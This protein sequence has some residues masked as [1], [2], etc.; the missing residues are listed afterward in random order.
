M[1]AKTS[2]EIMTNY[3]LTL[4]IAVGL[5]FPAFSQAWKIAD[6]PLKTPW[7]EQVNPASVLPEYPRPQMTRDR[8]Q[9]LNG[10]WEFQPAVCLGVGPVGDSAATA[11]PTGLVSADLY[12]AG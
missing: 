10:V 6:A 8:W 11:H 3:V 2:P 4:L 1:A 5:T 9:S 7:A 12:R